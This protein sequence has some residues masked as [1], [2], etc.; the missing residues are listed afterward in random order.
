MKRD[1]VQRYF[2]GTV[3]EEE[4]YLTEYQTYQDALKQIGKF[5]DSVY[6]NKRIHSALGYLTPVQYEA[7]WRAEQ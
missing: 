7:Q 4:V 2:D 6:N 5:I 1:F 3:E